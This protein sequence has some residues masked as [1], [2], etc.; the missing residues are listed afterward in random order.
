MGVAHHGL[1]DDSAHVA[2]Y[3][4]EWAMARTH[5]DQRETVQEV[6][7]D[8]VEYGSRL[9]GKQCGVVDPETEN[10]HRLAQGFGEQLAQPYSIQKVFRSKGGYVV[11]EVK[12]VAAAQAVKKDHICDR[13]CIWTHAQVEDCVRHNLRV[14]CDVG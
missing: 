2:A 8:L 4:H 5:T 11:T 10:P 9:R 7:C 13:G 3:K 14:I 1:G 12:H 6:C